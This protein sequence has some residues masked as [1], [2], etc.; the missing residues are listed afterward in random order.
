VRPVFRRQTAGSHSMAKQKCGSDLTFW[1]DL[2][3]ESASIR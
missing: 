1:N 2:K 3:C